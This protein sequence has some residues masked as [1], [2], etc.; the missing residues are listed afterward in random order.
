MLEALIRI[1]DPPKNSPKAKGD[2]VVVKL[3]PA[4]WSD[5][6]R[7]QFLIVKHEDATLES[8]LIEQRN[9]G[10]RFPCIANPY[11][12]FENEKMLVRS[13]KFVDAEKITKIPKEDIT[14]PS[15]T[16]PILEKSDILVEIREAKK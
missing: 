14:D 12:V 5:L 2:F 8:M 10:E 6:E 9:N 7:K 15:K 3:S 13:E 1:T 4:V 11:A 16:K